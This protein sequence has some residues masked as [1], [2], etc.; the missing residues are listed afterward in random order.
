MGNDAGTEL[1]RE[2]QFVFFLVLEDPGLWVN[3]ALKRPPAATSCEMIKPVTL[4][5]NLV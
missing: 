3:Y 5:E 2:K 1:I 4:T